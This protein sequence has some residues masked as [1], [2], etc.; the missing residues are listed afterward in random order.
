VEP[1]GK[2]DLNNLIYTAVIVSHNLPH[3]YHCEELN[4]KELSITSILAKVGHFE[5][6][7]RLEKVDDQNSKNVCATIMR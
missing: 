4:L 2:K 3:H 7:F 5:E 1:I 6:R